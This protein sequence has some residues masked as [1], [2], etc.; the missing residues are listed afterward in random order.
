[1]RGSAWKVARLNIMDNNNH[2]LLPRTFRNYSSRYKAN[3]CRFL[4]LAYLL[5]CH[6]YCYCNNSVPLVWLYYGNTS[7]LSLNFLLS[8]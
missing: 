3:M 4:H 6:R 5:L 8:Q 7:I 2:F 1:M